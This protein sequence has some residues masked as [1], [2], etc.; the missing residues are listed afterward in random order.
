MKALIYISEELVLTDK[1]HSI[2][3]ALNSYF[4]VVEQERTELGVY[5]KLENNQYD[6]VISNVAKNSELELIAS[7]QQ[8]TKIYFITGDKNL[9]N[10]IHNKYTFA[11]T[12]TTLESL[13]DHFVQ[14]NKVE[15]SQKEESFFNDLS[16]E[17][18]AA[19]DV[20]QQIEPYEEINDNTLNQIPGVKVEY[21]VDPIYTRTRQIQKTLFAQQ[22]WS[23]HK[24]VG[25]WSPVG[26][27]GVSTFILNFSLYLAQRRIYTTVLEGLTTKPILK[28]TLSRFT[29]VPPEWVSY[30][31]TI[32]EDNEPRSASWIYENVVFLP[33]VKE[34][35]KY[36][37]NPIL[38]EAYMT[39]T[40]IVD[41]TLV[42]LPSGPLQDYSRDSLHYVDE[43]WILFDDSYHELLNWKKYILELQN[44]YKI[45]IH[46]IM[47]K[48]YSFSQ[49]TKI[50]K[51]MNLPLI[52]T[53]PAMDELV[54]SNYYQD[55]PL[56]HVQEASEKLIPAYQDI[57]N[58]LFKNSFKT[59]ITEKAPQKA[60]GFF[61]KLRTSILKARIQ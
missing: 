41:V 35:L 13:L 29:K 61:K 59:K 42:D 36:T 46:L 51:E 45:N 50:S 44:K 52:T 3:T 7:A 10:F 24:I 17:V 56:L 30:A 26:R 58:H 49:S 55:K 32:Q 28:Q 19:D 22:Q 37:W 2:L 34:D 18:L 27:A 15:D 23:D 1:D 43:L 48:A 5:Y 60:D 9:L 20:V 39:T 21:E 25:V 11:N 31:S 53:I 6:Y 38:I 8:P 33:C 47:S 40:K 54:M 16:S 14:P 4:D 12:F 57:A